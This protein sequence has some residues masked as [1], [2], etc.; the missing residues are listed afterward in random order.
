[1]DARRR[2]MLSN[3]VSKQQS[4]ESF[5]RAHFVVLRELIGDLM[6]ATSCS[7]KQKK[8]A[9]DL[10][11]A[12]EEENHLQSLLVDRL[13]SRFAVSRAML[14]SFLLQ[15]RTVEMRFLVQAGTM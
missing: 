8:T 3:L 11:G 12:A 5:D 9:S 1:M 10:R 7:Q 15:L 4:T 6:E 13:W 14:L 2:W